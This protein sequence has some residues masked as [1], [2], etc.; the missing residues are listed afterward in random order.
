MILLK[1]DIPCENCAKAIKS[2][3]ASIPGIL[4]V[5]CSVEKNEIRIETLA[6]SVKEAEIRSLAISQLKTTGRTC[7]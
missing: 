5:D 1:T 7:Q 2:T 4:T 6:N 3:L